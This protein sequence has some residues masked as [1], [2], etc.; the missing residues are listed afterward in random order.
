MHVKNKFCN[1]FLKLKKKNLI[2][3]T[4]MKETGWFHIILSFNDNIIV[5]VVKL[6]DHK[7]V[8][9]IYLILDLNYYYR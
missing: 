4:V 2:T 8:I 7:K 3:P 5:E 6:I 9:H 1:W